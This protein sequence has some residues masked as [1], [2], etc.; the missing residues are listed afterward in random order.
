[1]TDAEIASDFLVESE[2]RVVEKSSVSAVA[3]EA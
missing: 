3:K 2:K 1:V